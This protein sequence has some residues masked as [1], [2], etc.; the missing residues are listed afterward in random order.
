VASYADA[1]AAGLIASLAHQGSNIT[2]STF[3]NPELMAK[4]VE[5]LKE[6]VPSMTQAAV[7]LKPGHAVNGEIL[8]AME[9]TAKALKAGLQPF[10]ASG[11]SEFE[12]TFAAAADKQIGGVVIQDHPIFI[13]NAKELAALTAKHR[14]A[15]IGF[16]EWTVAD[17]L[18]A[19]GVSFHDLFRRA[20]YFVDKILKGAKPGDLPVEQPTKFQLVIN[21]KIG[22]ALGLAIPDSLLARADE[23]I[24]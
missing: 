14:L 4:R 13:A 8:H 6:A 3:L 7:L 20:A 16:L 11:P 9:T 1:V 15:S 18:M 5:L 17:G 21:L 22:K 24:E 2:G 12:D 10:E 23:V 19:Y